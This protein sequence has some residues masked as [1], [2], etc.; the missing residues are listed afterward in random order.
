MHVRAASPES[1]RNRDIYAG[2][3]VPEF[4]RYS[5]AAGPEAFTLVDGGGVWPMRGA[6][7]FS[8]TANSLASGTDYVVSVY[9][10]ATTT[11]LKQTVVQIE[12]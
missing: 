9:R 6:P 2:V 5:E 7:V 12:R 10:E 1:R 4:W 11:A 3:G 8:W